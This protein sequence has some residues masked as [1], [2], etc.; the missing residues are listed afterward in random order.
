VSSVWVI[1]DWAL[2]FNEN[3][4]LDAH[5]LAC[6][7]QLAKDSPKRARLPARPRPGEPRDLG[8]YRQ[9]L[10]E[11]EDLVRAASPAPARE[12]ANRRGINHSTLKSY[13]KRGRRYLT[14]GDL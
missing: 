9:L 13:L 3:I 5:M 14:E 11:Y 1:P 10:S 2:A 4:D 12:L 6:L 8:F 7:N